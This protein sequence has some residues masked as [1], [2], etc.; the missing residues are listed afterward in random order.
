MT[1]GD[2]FRSID[3]DGGG[4]ILFEEFARWALSKQLDLP[5]DDDFDGGDAARVAVAGGALGYAAERAHAAR[6]A[7]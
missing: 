1:L 4:L 3:A 2:E 7:E 5:E 6:A